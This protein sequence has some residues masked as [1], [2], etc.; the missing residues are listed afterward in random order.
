MAV[1]G[2]EGEVPV[3]AL[4][5]RRVG[6]M[7][8]AAL[9]KPA[10]VVALAQI[11]RVHDAQTAMGAH[12]AAGSSM[13]KQ[14]LGGPVAIDAT[15]AV[16][17]AHQ[18]EGLGKVH[19]RQ[20]EGAPATPVGAGGIGGNKGAARPV[21]GRLAHPDAGQALCGLS[22]LAIYGEDP[23]GRPT[24]TPRGTAQHPRG[25]AGLGAPIG[26]AHARGAEDGAGGPLGQGDGRCAAVEGGDA[27]H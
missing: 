20:L 17:V 9:Q 3:G 6:C 7:E 1:K 5:K 10:P 2:A 12:A 23:R 27:S 13:Q 26:A 8:G 22:A 18:A 21:D 25:E 11:I 16:L 24:G 4:G 19:L 15:G 14:D